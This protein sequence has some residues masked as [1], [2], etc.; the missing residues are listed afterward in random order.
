VPHHP[1]RGLVV[2]ECHHATADSYRA[3]IPHVRAPGPSA[4]CCLW[5]GSDYRAGSVAQTRT[6]MNEDTHG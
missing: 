3:L 2:D 6:L 1:K 4:R 5:C